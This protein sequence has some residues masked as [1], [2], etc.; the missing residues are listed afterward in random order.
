MIV[1]VHTHIFPPE[2]C[3]N[4]ADWFPGEEA[5]CL[6]YDSPRARLVDAEG[7]IAAMD[8]NGVDISVTFGFP[9]KKADHFKKHNDYIL[10]SVAK[11]SKR[12]RGLCC[13]DL[14]AEEAESEV[15]RCL[16][17]GLSGVGELAFSQS[18]IEA[19]GIE[20]LKP[21]MAICRKRNLPVMIHTNEPVG[22][23][24]PGKTPNTLS[25]IYRMVSTFPENKI[26]LAHWGGG[27]FLYH[28]MKKEVKQRFENMYVD[29][30]ASP[31][32]YDPMIYKVAGLAAAPEKILFGS[33]YPLIRPQRYFQEMEAAG[34]LP[35]EK[36]KIC[37][38]NAVLLFNLKAD[39]RAV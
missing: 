34:L 20:R 24:Y 38:G 19:E 13:G 17:A 7:L 23:A 5:F 32:L 9:W 1:D 2:V 11:Y 14:F 10:D 30:A 35:E 15:E 6:L 16:D 18:G 33:D 29:T 39:G 27:V 28:L 3:S 25:Q 37:G 8:E 31:F 4:R 21:I 36:Q 22:H 26:I 12:L